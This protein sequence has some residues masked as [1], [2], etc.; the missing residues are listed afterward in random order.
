MNVRAEAPLFTIGIPAHNAESYLLPCIASATRQTFQ[1]YEIVIVDDGSTDSTARLCDK[2]ASEN[3][4]VKVWHKEN[5]GP[6]LTRREIA[7][8][9]NGEY[10]VFLDS[11]DC[12]RKDTLELCCEAIEQEGHPDIILFDYSTRENYADT[13]ANPILKHGKYEGAAIRKARE[14]S[15]AGFL[16]ALWAKAIKKS[17]FDLDEDYSMLKGMRHGEDYLQMLPIIN[18]A[19]SLLYLDETLYFYRRSDASGT[20]HFRDSQIHDLDTLSKRVRSYAKLWSMEGI[21]ETGIL[22]QY[23]Y[24]FKILALDSTMSKTD[25]LAN[26]EKL[27][28]KLLPLITKESMKDLSVPWKAFVKSI[29]SNTPKLTKAL[30]L[31]DYRIRKV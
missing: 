22:R 9:A 12:I 23:C 8:R 11:D 24:P 20:F 21:A 28:R 26:Y 13:H 18:A 10:I 19:S 31:A 3:P 6:L 27:R 17:L 1:N 25:Y 14:A 16:N 30:A 2:L 5:E 29:G 7:R 4:V 15:C